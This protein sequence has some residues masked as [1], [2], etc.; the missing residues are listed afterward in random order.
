VPGL[1]A[2]LLAVER[3]LVNRNNQEDTT[4]SRRGVNRDEPCPICLSTERTRADRGDVGTYGTEADCLAYTKKVW[5][6]LRSLSLLQTMAS[7]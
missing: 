1:A 3:H 4:I 2:H 5:T 6:D 7:E